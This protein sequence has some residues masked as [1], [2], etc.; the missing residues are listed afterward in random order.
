MKL[1]NFKL[2][3]SFAIRKK[4][5]TCNISTKNRNNVDHLYFPKFHTNSHSGN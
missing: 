5:I 3:N 4:Y 1:T 2:Y